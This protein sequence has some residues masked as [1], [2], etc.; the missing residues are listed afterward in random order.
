MPIQYINTGSSANAGNGDSI[1]LAFDKVNRNF[2]FVDT[3][4]DAL[5]NGYLTSLH[6]ATTASI[7]NLTVTGTTHLNTVESATFL[8]QT[9]FENITVSN[10]STLNLV[11]ANDAKIDTLE[12]LTSLSVGNYQ[13]AAINDYND[14][15]I[16]KNDA[17]G[18]AVVL[19][20]T[21]ADSNSKLI[22]KDNIS[23]GLAI[24]HQN[25][26]NLAGD[27][28]PGENYIY[29]ET[30]TDVIHIGA[31][32]DIKFSASEAKYYNPLLPE[33]PSMVI[34]SIDGTVHV[35]SSATFYSDVYGIAGAGANAGTLDRLTS[36]DLSK[37]VILNN[38][39][40]LVPSADLA[41]DLGSTS[42]QWRSLYLGTSTIYLGGTP[43]SVAGGVLTVN[44]SPVTGGGAALGDR[45]TAGTT[46]TLVLLDDGTL[47]LTHP[48]E[49]WS[50][51]YSLEI[52]KAAGNYHTFKSAYGLSLQATP[53]PNGYGLN[54][55]TNFVDIFHDGVSV[56][57][58]DNTW[59]F[60]TDGKL[61]LPDGTVIDPYTFTDQTTVFPGYV[62]STTT[63]GIALTTGEITN[64]II[65]PGTDFTAA[66]GSGTN[67]NPIAISGKNGVSITSDSNNWTFGTDGVITLPSGNTRI[68][69]IDGLDAIIGN[70]GTGV[71]VASQGMN[72]FVVLEWIGNNENIG[73]TA[74]TQVAAVIV[75][76]PIAS[77]SGTVQIATGLATGPT[78]NYIWEFGAD[79]ILRIPDDIQDAN[80]SV[81]RVA[82][83]S[84]SPTRVNGQLWFNSEEGRTYIKYN[85]QWLDASPTIVPPASTY[86]DQITIDGS[87][88][89][90]NDST[91]TIDDNGT[92]LV[93]GEQVTGSGGT[94]I[95]YTDGQS[96]YTSTV[97]LGY[98][99]EV[100]VDD[101]HLN[102]NGIG[103][104]EIGS[105]AFNTKIFS[106][107]DPGNEPKVI[108]VRA[109]NDD[110]TFGPLGWL[111]LPGGSVIKD[112]IGAIR[113][114]PSGA[115]SATQA[116]LIYPTAQ[117]G[118]HIHLTAGGGET[119]LY[120][121]SDSQF[122]KV[123]HSG[124]IVVGTNGN[125]ALTQWTFGTDGVL[126]L[127][128]A[129][130]ILGNSSDP[131]VYIETST[132]STTSTWTF[133]TDGV[134][135]LP[136]ATPVI[137]GGGTGTDVSIVASTGTNTST[138][139]FAASGRI[140]FPTHT[141]PTTSH[142]APGDKAGM[143]AFDSVGMYYCTSD[144]VGTSTEYN[145]T[146]NSSQ[147]TWLAFAKSSYP[148]ALADFTVDNSTGW[149]VTYDGNTYNITSIDEYNGSYW[150]VYWAET[151]TI[152]NADPAMITRLD[153][154]IWVRQA[155]SS[156]GG[157][158]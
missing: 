156:V 37:V 146:I 58:N 95:E 65:I 118:N 41:Y 102:L 147:P 119:D 158:T 24:L 30:P 8:N 157:W 46:A 64:T 81:V 49:W 100:D 148:N 114:E 11:T 140:T 23:G 151:I 131:N 32:S 87:T 113:L 61:T 34:Q 101:S 133:G 94:H 31:Y 72:G 47:K 27:F 137:K 125:S 154:H 70:T 93:N 12:V 96:G 115:S 21:N 15:S 90:I 138:W 68:G 17:T 149:T 122:V 7:H 132:T 29:G 71:G 77:T 141:V 48:T 14:F 127:S 57:V 51:A 10:T 43:L 28:V 109:D 52:Q 6:I 106:T 63:K 83:T 110:W 121:G 139:T 128:T 78:S 134:L 142:G 80:G 91:L 40:S 116:L 88:I 108:V 19:L 4:I 104:W 2:S 136:A 126:T 145:V 97:D 111:T 123:D 152:V 150:R 143:L 18:L 130:T 69:N 124:T 105:N 35:Y 60:G 73:T 85:G 144:F 66:V 33:T 53:V 9:Y 79:G 120:L 22:V 67:T 20:N 135:T 39:G 129:S 38:N 92:L 75:N 103:T 13:I 1:R 26:T 3:S 45:L 55:N 62:N 74:S 5:S 117:D 36:Q 44:G 153:A 50:G 84:T 86:L 42:S 107:D 89:N 98:N 25:L 99:F 56:N 54:T 76:S 16:I 59:G 82:T 112:G 155:W